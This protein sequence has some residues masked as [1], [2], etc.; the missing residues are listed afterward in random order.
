MCTKNKLI[1]FTNGTDSRA[2]RQQMNNESR[3]MFAVISLRS[4]FAL[5]SNINSCSNGAHSAID[6]ANSA[7]T[8]EISL[9]VSLSHSLFV[10]DQIWI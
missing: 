1:N 4:H 3:T 9:S 7:A 2:Q 5:G 8:I 10:S 6:I